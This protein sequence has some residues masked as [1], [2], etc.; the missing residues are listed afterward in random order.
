MKIT[1]NN[2]YENRSYFV[3]IIIKKNEK[4][5]CSNNRQTNKQTRIQKNSIRRFC[6]GVEIWINMK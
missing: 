2:Q 3:K 4:Y 6:K 5:F 1:S